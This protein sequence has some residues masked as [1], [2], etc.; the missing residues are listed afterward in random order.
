MCQTKSIL[1]DI[2]RVQPVTLMKIKLA[3]LYR[4]R[5]IQIL[6]HNDLCSL[7]EQKIFVDVI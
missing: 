4:S 6:V 7:Q 5:A 3:K 2:H 1:S